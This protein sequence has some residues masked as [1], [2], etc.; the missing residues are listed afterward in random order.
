MHKK[1]ISLESH[2]PDVF[3]FL[4]QVWEALLWVLLPQPG[5]K[6]QGPDAGGIGEAHRQKAPGAARSMP[7]LPPLAVCPILHYMSFFPETK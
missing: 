3:P 7:G 5:G 4:S 1:I 2:C 6:P